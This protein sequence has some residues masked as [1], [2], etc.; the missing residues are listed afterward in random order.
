MTKRPREKKVS[1]FSKRDVARSQKL[2]IVDKILSRSQVKALE[3]VVTPDTIVVVV[4]FTNRSLKFPLIKKLFE[5]DRL[6]QFA[7]HYFPSVEKFKTQDLA[8]DHIDE[9]YDLL[10]SQGRIPEAQ[11][12]KLYQHDNVDLFFKR[13]LIERLADFLTC[14]RFVTLIQKEVPDVLWLPSLGSQ[15]ML[16]FVVQTKGLQEHL[17]VFERVQTI[18]LPKLASALSRVWQKYRALTTIKLV[19]PWALF[20]LRS[21]ASGSERKSHLL[22]MRMYQSGIGFDGKGRQSIDWIID[23]QRITK[24]DVLFVGETPIPSRHHE[25]LQKNQYHFLNFD[26]KQAFRRMRLSFVLRRLLLGMFVEVVPLAWACLKAPSSTTLVCAKAWFDFLRWTNFLQQYDLKF[27]L[28]YN[29]NGIPHLT[30]NC[31]FQNHGVKCWAYMQTGSNDQAFHVDEEGTGRHVD[32][33]FVTYDKHFVWTDQQVDY[34][35]SQKSRTTSFEVSGP[36]WSYPLENSEVMAEA[37]ASKWPGEKNDL[38]LAL[39]PTS[40]GAKA[41]NHEENH[42][43]FLQGILRLLDTP[44]FANM[45]VLFKSK[46]NY[47]SEL[48]Y[49]EPET[50]EVFQKFKA[51]PRVLILDSSLAVNEIV[52]VSNL[53][54]SMAFTGTSFEALSVYKRA[55]FFDALNR[56]PKSYYRHFPN[57]IAHSDEELQRLAKS[58]LDLTEEDLRHYVDKHIKPSYGDR[59]GQFAIEF[60]RDRLLEDA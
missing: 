22:G 9:L 35:K 24:D 16:N 2:I 49:E 44:D 33:S 32:F 59:S 57:F 27:Y 17:A 58:W 41:M 56:F 11:V 34:A 4:H 5:E 18:A 26:Q 6:R 36:L 15:E 21:L 3:K 31:L 51:H 40:V 60:V 55:L 20:S 52:S 7:W 29:N 54:I 23:G 14:V 30:R 48:G 8:F 38:L 47:E 19:V 46:G 53:V 12:K 42:L 37:I 28:S 45:K 1:P 25:G 39:F 43:G 13:D 10:L 50:Y